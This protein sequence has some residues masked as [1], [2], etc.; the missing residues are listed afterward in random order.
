MSLSTTTKSYNTALKAS[1][2]QPPYLHHR[3]KSLR[4]FPYSD[5]LF[6]RIVKSTK[7]HW[8]IFYWLMYT[9]SLMQGVPWGLDGPL[10]L[11]GRSLSHQRLPWLP[12][13]HLSR[14]I[15]LT[16]S[17]KGRDQQRSEV[18]KSD[19]FHPERKQL[20]QKR[21]SHIMA[22]EYNAHVTQSH[23]KN[24]LFNLTLVNFGLSFAYIT[25]LR[26]NIKHIEER[27]QNKVS[28]VPF[29]FLGSIK[30]AA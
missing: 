26:K 22:E 20:N 8:M 30:Q 13:Q 6:A 27:I 28:N 17:L 1:A 25:F 10:P 23:L 12:L 4:G 11:R 19:G 9:Q 2:Q 3:N 21:P 24:D 16:L 7:D 5:P 14:Q 29:D 15:Q 18:I